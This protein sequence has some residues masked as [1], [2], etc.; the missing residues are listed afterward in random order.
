[1]IKGMNHVGISVVSLDRSIGFYR[2]LLGMEVVEQEAFEGIRYDRILALDGVAGKTA[3]LRHGNMQVEL[4]EFSSP[5]PRKADC[6]RP[7][8][9]HGIT[10]FCIEV[11]DIDGV[12][13]RLRTAGIRFHCSPL[14][15]DG[16]ARA[17]YG[18]D[19][20]G[21]VFELLEIRPVPNVVG[22]ARGA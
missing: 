12:Y 1:M 3:L 15:F 2:D 11:T 17:T 18:R 19:P 8:C 13:E 16:S 6:D 21:N 10:H 7:V 14:D 20:D 22:E 5:H 9:D 4:F